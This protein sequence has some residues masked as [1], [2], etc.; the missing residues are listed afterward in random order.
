MTGNAS[1]GTEPTERS[2]PRP[3]GTTR[4]GFALPRRS[5]RG[6]VVV[7]IGVSVSWLG[8]SVGLLTLGVTARFS[9]DPTTAGAAYRAMAV[10]VNTLIIPVSLIALMS[11]VALSIG[12]PWGLTRHYWIVVKLVLTV[13]TTALS[14]FSL[15][16]LVD[17]AVAALAAGAPYPNTETMNSLTAAPTVSTTI[18]VFMVVVSV[19]KPWGRIRGRRGRVMP[20]GG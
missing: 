9:G 20:G 7:H 15:R 11:G 4:K 16:P 14:I 13:I 17:E 5:R 6:L 2:R 10:L 3:P 12:R 19:L 1:V 18:Y 8:V